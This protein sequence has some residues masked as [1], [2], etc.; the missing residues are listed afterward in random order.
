MWGVGKRGGVG[1]DGGRVGFAEELQVVY[2]IRVSA[3][4]DGG[5]GKLTGHTRREISQAHGRNEKVFDKNRD[6]LASGVWVRFRIPDLAGQ[7]R[8]HRLSSPYCHLCTLGCLGR[9]HLR[10]VPSRIVMSG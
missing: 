6:G 7:A 9:R 5:G 10:R 8:R 2:R 4:W 1:G 3:L